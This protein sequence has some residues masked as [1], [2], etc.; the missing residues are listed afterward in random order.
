MQ[1][2]LQLYSVRD[3]LA[4]DFTGTMQRVAAMGYPAVEPAGVYGAGIESA[5]K[6]FSDLG[7]KV[8]SAHF[9]L[10]VG[11]AKNA[12]LEGA[13]TLGCE[14]MI[15]AYIPPEEFSSVDRIQY[16][17]DQLN[18][19]SANARAAGFTLLYHNHWWEF[20]ESFDQKTVIDIMLE[21]L[22]PAAGLELDV[23]WA[24]VGG[25][26]PAAT[27][28]RLGDRVKL[29][30]FKDGGLSE[31]VH[32]TAIGAGKVHWPPIMQAVQHIS[33]G[34]VEIDRV[35]DGLSVVDAAAESVTFLR[36]QGYM[37]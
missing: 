5:A 7:L 17:C 22:D 10:P 2:G 26:D 1:I 35:A 3:A 11:D 32:M 28:Q 18:E 8:P 27:V 29:L 33:W 31:H 4:Q 14:Y 21:H 16:W 9:P 23:Y 25:H 30:H 36:A 6:L 34:Y 24:E 37:A 19:G 13:A 15:C 12:S 20:R